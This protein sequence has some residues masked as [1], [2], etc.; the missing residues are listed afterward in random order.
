[1]RALHVACCFLLTTGWGLSFGSPNDL[2]FAPIVNA[3]GSLLLICECP[4][5]KACECR[6]AGAADCRAVSSE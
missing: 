1:M 6:E 2:E 5:E 4:T 3:D